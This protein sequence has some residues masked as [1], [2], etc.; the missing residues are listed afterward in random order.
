MFCKKCGKELP[1]ETRFCPDCG[2]ELTS[3]PSTT[4]TYQEGYAQPSNYLVLGIITTVLCCVPFGIVSIVFASKV[5]N[6]WNTGHKAEAIQNSEKAKR[7]AV[8]GMIVSAV[9]ILIYLILMALV[10]V[11]AISSDL[12]Y[13]L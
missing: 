2:S 9:V 7:W 10:L 11:G 4:S 8:A 12:L 1:E 13:D 3:A 6:L 5:D